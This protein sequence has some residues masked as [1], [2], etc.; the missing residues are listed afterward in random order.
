MCVCV[1]GVH[2]HS[3]VCDPQD[4]YL[5]QQVWVEEEELLPPPH[6]AIACR[7]RARGPVLPLGGLATFRLASFLI[8]S[9]LREGGSAELG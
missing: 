8:S 2:A 6:L 7:C 5:G 3:W 9:Y 1:G 4:T